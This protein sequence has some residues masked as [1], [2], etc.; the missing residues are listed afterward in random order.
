MRGPASIVLLATATG[1][2]G[3]GLVTS[4]VLTV[5]TVATMFAAPEVAADVLSGIVGLAAT[6]FPLY[7]MTWHAR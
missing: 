6:A 5:W 7:A 2:L 1:A 4:T 3:I